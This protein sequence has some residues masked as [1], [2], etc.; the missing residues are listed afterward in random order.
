MLAKIG[1]SAGTL[2]GP[3]TLYDNVTK[4][5]SNRL[6]SSLPATRGQLQGTDVRLKA[7]EAELEEEKADIKEY[8]AVINRLVGEVNSLTPVGT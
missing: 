7:V 6:D 8:K 2:A 3:E 4:G 1:H 5:I